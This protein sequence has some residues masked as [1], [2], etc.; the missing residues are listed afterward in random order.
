MSKKRVAPETIVS[1][2]VPRFAGWILFF[3]AVIE[4]I[5]IFQDP[6]QFFTRI[7]V[8]LL[9]FLIVNASSCYALSIMAGKNPGEK[10]A[11]FKD[12]FVASLIINIVMV[13][14]VAAYIL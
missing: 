4:L 5:V 7:H 1:E 6:T 11:I 3:G 9:F 8:S 12:W 10:T 14:S 2:K 13:G